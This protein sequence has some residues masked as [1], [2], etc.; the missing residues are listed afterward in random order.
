MIKIKRKRKRK[1]NSHVHIIDFNLKIMFA[2]D[3]FFLSWWRFHF[4]LSIPTQYGINWWLISRSLSN[5]HHHKQIFGQYNCVNYKGNSTSQ[6]ENSGKH[7]DCSQD[8]E[9]R[10]ERIPLTQSGKKGSFTFGI[11]THWICWAFSD[12]WSM[13]PMHRLH[14]SRGSRTRT[15]T[16][17]TLIILCAHCT[18]NTVEKKHLF[19]V[20]CNLM[21][22]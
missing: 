2:V 17:T 22:K 18:L 14:Y 10:E 3:G 11:V 6:A 12:R 21:S 20:R 19:L 7:H 5:S 9:M 15:R 1:S 16:H 4:L 8:V 13:A